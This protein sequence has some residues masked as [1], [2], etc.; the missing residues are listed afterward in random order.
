MMGFFKEK[1]RELEAASPEPAPPPLAPSPAGYG[2]DQ[3]IALMRSFPADLQRTDL[4]VRIVKQTLE[5]AHIGMAGIIADATRREE[6]LE[7]RLRTLQGE[8]ASR[9]QE[10]AARTAEVARLQ[11]EFDDISRTKERL[12]SQ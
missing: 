7:T 3:A 4:V 2:I 10:I 6:Q 1:E 9:Q 11:A 12:S 5:S 8:I